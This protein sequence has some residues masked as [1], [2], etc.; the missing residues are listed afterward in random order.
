MS[1]RDILKDKVVKDNLVTDCVQLIEHQ[2]AA[3]GG[4]SGLGLKATY[5]VVKGIGPAYI[6]GAI[7]RLLPEALNALDPIWHEGLDA[8]DPVAYLS[9]HQRRAADC[10]LSTTDARI[11]RTN[12]GLV[13]ASYNKLRESVKGD[14]EAAIPGLANILA[15]RV[16]VA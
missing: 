8:G 1:L 13:K 4:L 10:L 16:L 6:P 2:V 9:Q 3:K 14:V 5:G 12:N 15:T 7:E 11:E